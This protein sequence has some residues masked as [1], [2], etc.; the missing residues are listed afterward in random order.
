M[1]NSIKKTKLEIVLE[2]LLEVG[3]I[4]QRESMKL[5]ESW[6]LSAIIHTLRKAGIQ[7]DT[8]QEPHI[9]GYHA[10]YILIGIEQAERHLEAIRRCR[11]K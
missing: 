10:R 2:Y 3:S 4:T 7:I 9:N 8:R 1:S 11:D 5:C 6:R